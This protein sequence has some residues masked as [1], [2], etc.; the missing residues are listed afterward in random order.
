MALKTKV[1]AGNITNLSDARYC[2]GMGVDWLSFPINIVNPT[3]FKEITDWVAGP[4]SILEVNTLADINQIEQY[5]VAIVEISYQQIGLID[6]LTTMTWGII[7]PVS[8]WD[9]QKA[10]L[11][12]QKDK[13]EYLLLLPDIPDLQVVREIA[14]HFKV[15]IHQSEFHSIDQLLALPIEGINILGDDELKP[16]LKDYE[17]LSSVLEELEVID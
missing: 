7:L 4:Q 3:L 10:E 1:K 6:Q 16:G 2:A 12:K 11:I 8:K 14:R 5:P 17:R 13:I 9:S 15:L